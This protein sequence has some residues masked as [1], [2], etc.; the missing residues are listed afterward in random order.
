MR[1]M[2]QQG[3]INEEREEAGPKSV[4]SALIKI[5]CGMIATSEI[6]EWTPASYRSE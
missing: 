5:D 4:S 3:Y 1:C 6:H 2:G